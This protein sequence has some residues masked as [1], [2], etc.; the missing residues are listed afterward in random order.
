MVD[1][2]VLKLAK[3]FSRRLE[4][5]GAEA[6][7]LWG[8]RVLGDAYEESDVDVQ[9]IGKGP[10]YRLERYRGYL[11]SVSWA[12]RR[13]ISDAFKDPSQVCGLIPAWRNAF[14]I[15]DQ[16][17]IAKALKQ[18]AKQWK[19]K[20]FDKQAQ[21]WVAEQITGYAEEVHRLVGSMQ[22]GRSN[23]AAVVRSLLAIHM[24]PILAVHYRIFYDT[25]NQL[26]DLVSTKMGIEWARVQGIALGLNG[27]SFEETCKAALELFILT[28]KRIE[29]LL[30]S[31]QHAVI[32]HS[33]S[34]ANQL[35]AKE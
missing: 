33:C 4:D 11:F 9:V 34:I 12:T 28:A 15:H 31:R 21:Q 6:T 24:A 26:W 27:E 2:E 1:Q 32:T 5:Q 20:P 7:V 19:W 13:E 29:P 3:T 8:S 35:L 22:L 14:I 30:N 10:S 16:Q 18:E 23:V 25:E 17:G